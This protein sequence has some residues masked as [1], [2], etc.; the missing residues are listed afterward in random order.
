[1]RSFPSM[2]LFLLLVLGGAPYMQAQP[3][4]QGSSQTFSVMEAFSGGVL[5][6]TAD[7]AVFRSTHQGASYTELTQVTP[8]DHLYGIG[9]N[10]SVVIAT[11]TDGLLYRSDFSADPTIWTNTNAN[12]IL[13]DLRDVKSDG[14]TTWVA[15]GDEVLV[16]DD[17]GLNW[18]NRSPASLDSLSAVV[19]TGTAG[20]WVAAG[21]LFGAEAYYSV[22]GGQTWTASTLPPGSS[23]LLD[24]EVDVSGNVLAVGEGGEILFSSDQGVVFSSVT[25]VNV[26]QDLNGVVST[27]EGE[28][29]LVGTQR[30]LYSY[31]SMSGQSEELLD[32]V[33]SGLDTGNDLVALQDSVVL[34]GVEQV[35]PPVISA[36]ATTSLEPIEVTLT[37]GAGTDTTLYTTDSTSASSTSP[38][39]TSPFVIKESGSVRAVSVLDGIYSAEV[40]EAFTITLHTLTVLSSGGQMLLTLEPSLVGYGYE[41]EQSTD[42]TD[43]LGWSSV[44]PLVAGTGSPLTWTRPQTPSPVF[45]RVQISFSAP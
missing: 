31:D 12:P 23:P 27:G 17:N 34:A 5:A 29:V 14:S 18:T 39:Y 21:G 42:P 24:V 33:Q 9:A 10:G 32:P 25:S 43:P 37:P 28:W 4:P 15:V 19:F 1:M 6:L 20:A 13:G 44:E 16:S 36:P 40:S 45:W 11:G 22:D 7:G 8:P 2:L 41:L 30:V 3:R 26:S 35:P 38:V